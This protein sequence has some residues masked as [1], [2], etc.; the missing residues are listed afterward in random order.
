MRPLTEYVPHIVISTMNS[1]KEVGEWY[2]FLIKDQAYL[3][4][5]MKA[6]IAR[7]IKGLKTDTDKARAVFGYVRDESSFN[8]INR[9]FIPQPTYTGDR[10]FGISGSVLTGRAWNG[11]F[12]IAKQQHNY[13]K[14][15]KRTPGYCIGNARDKS[16]NRTDNRNRNSGRILGQPCL[17]IQSGTYYN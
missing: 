1:W 4:A 7:K 6:L 2:T 5:E 3:N 14:R 8:F 16:Y 15:P 17:F 12:S 11:N 13:G 9:I 10:H